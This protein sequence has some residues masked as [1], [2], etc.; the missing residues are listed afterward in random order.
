MQRQQKLL[1]SFMIWGLVLCYG[2]TV[3]IAL[4]PQEIEIAKGSTVYLMFKDSKGNGWTGSGFV[5][6]DDQI[7]TNY[8]VVENMSIGVAQLGEK[9]EM[10][11][12][13]RILA[14]DKKC[15]L[16]IVKVTEL[17]CQHSLL[18]TVTWFRRS[19]RFTLWAIQ[20][21]CEIQSQLAL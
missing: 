13:E 15:D 11:R 6:R 2:T 3:A 4:T 9:E 5:V 18:V 20:G 14:T 21:D 8:H 16:A 17:M 10:Y 12:V 1:L 19:I 7:A